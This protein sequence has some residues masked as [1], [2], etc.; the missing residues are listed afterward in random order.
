MVLLL[1]IGL[2]RVLRKAAV[3]L[4]YCRPQQNILS[5]TPLKMVMAEQTNRIGQLQPRHSLTD[6][7]PSR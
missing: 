2:L 5:D 6:T 7:G 4:S 3:K 1:M